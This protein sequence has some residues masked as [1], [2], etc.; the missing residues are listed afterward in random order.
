MSRWTK[1]Q[2]AD[3]EKFAIKPASVPVT[4]TSATEQGKGKPKR[5][6]AAGV[7]K[8]SEHQLQCQF[9]KWFRAQYPQYAM[10]LFAIPNANKRTPAQAAYLKA[11]GL[12]PGCWDLFL[13]IPKGEYG[14]MFIETKVVGNTLTD[15]QRA[16]WSDVKPDYS[17]S[18]CK[19]LEQFIE[20]VTTYLNQ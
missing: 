20:A 11:E 14:G 12:L 7:V 2:Y 9:I 8:I 1:G 17:F 10:R 16:F 6:K 18:V 4:G 3:F 19:T 13:C 15:N 5:E